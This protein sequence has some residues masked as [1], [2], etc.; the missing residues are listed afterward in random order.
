MLGGLELLGQLSFFLLHNP[1][2]FLYFAPRKG[3][4]FKFVMGISNA[5][6]GH[7]DLLNDL[8][9]STK[10]VTHKKYMRMEKGNELRY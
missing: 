6:L 9:K 5:F 8:H 1:E 10:G 3:L 7:I 4:S 2:R